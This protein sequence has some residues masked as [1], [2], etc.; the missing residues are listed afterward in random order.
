MHR[1]LP[2]SAVLLFGWLV[3]GATLLLGCGG[4]DTS[5]APS[6]SPDGAGGGSPTSDAE[7]P[8]SD[9]AKGDVGTER[10]SFFITSLAAL[11]DLSGNVNGFGGDLRFG[12]PD[13]LSGAD[14]I[15]RQIAQRSMPGNEKTWRAFLSVTKGPDGTP[16]HAV[17]RIGQGPWYDRL[18][19]IVALHSEDLVQQRP[20][21]ADPAIINDLPNEN[22]V[23][24][25]NPDGTGNVDNHDM[26]TG[27][28]AT[29]KLYSADWSSTC[30]DWT[31][32]VG[33]DGRP[34]CGHPWPTG[35]GGGGIGDRDG[36][37]IIGR[38]GGM[39]IGRDG[40]IMIGRDG[41]GIFP[42]GFDG[43]DFG[44]LGDLANWM[45]SLDEA[46]C[47][48][49]VHLVEMGPPNPSNPTVGSG[50]GYGGFYCFALTP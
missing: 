31:S 22:G 47:A 29:G 7:P 30:H 26:L 8:P 23:P 32:I 10:F 25:H 49:G 33:T 34:R 17:E 40:G 27:T 14:E 19:R 2:V 9:G 48:P 41:G 11:R 6:A 4:H 3:P 44:G 18:G 20:R 1:S 24:N 15:C 37:I 50:G 39:T 12:Q 21:A 28:N 13:G 35:G 38:D 42:P 45:S 16:I 36:G 5:G 46:G 43:G